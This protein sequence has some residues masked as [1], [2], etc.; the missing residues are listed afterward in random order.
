[1]KN[2]KLTLLAL[3]TAGALN[4]QSIDI[5]FGSTFDSVTFDAIYFADAS[6]NPFT[7]AII[8]VGY[9]GDISS[10]SDFSS[11]LGDFTQI[12]SATSFSGTPGYQ[13]ATTS[14]TTDV[15]GETPFV[16][17]LGGISDF[18]DASTATSYS[19]FG[20]SGWGTL[21]AGAIPPAVA[22]LL[23][24]TPDNIVVGSFAASGTG[25]TLSAVSTVVP[26]PSAFALLG[27]LFALTCVMLRRRA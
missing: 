6:S 3:F 13:P 26:E 21:P 7:D 9:F 25:G 11:Y 24:L 12:G 20:D 14:T 4:A 16:F 5:D 15:S 10:Q 23:T 2:I 1:M 8:T 27:G 22:N 17:V 18:A 19:I